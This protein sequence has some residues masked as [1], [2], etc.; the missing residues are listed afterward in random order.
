MSERVIVY[1]EE[2]QHKLT[3]HTI[4]LTMRNELELRAIAAEIDA[5]MSKSDVRSIT[6][7]LLEASNVYPEV[8]DF[9]NEAGTWNLQ[10]IDRMAKSLQAVVEQ[11]HQ[12]KVE[13][14]KESDAPPAYEPLDY[15]AAVQEAVKRLQQQWKDLLAGNLDLARRLYF[16]AGKWPVSLSALKDGRLMMQRIIDRKRMKPEHVELIDGD[17]DNE[18]WSTIPASE[19]ALII[20]TFR[21]GIGV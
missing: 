21:A 18:L 8:W 6:E 15:N 14:T 19:V 11:E 7:K 5:Y 16:S 9:F 3:L 17:V 13:A 10:T 4:P 2:G 20:D 12:L 1:G